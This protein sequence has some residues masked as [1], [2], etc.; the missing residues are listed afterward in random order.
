MGKHFSRRSFSSKNVNFVPKVGTF[1]PKQFQHLNFA[2]EKGRDPL[3]MPG[4]GRTKRERKRLVG[5]LFV[6]SLREILMQTKRISQREMMKRRPTN[7]FLS[8]LVRPC[9]GM[10]R[11]SRPFS[12]AKFKC[13][14]YTY[15]RYFGK[16]FTVLEQMFSLL[17]QSSH[18]WKRKN[19]W[20][21]VRPIILFSELNPA[22]GK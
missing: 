5:H 2:W 4:Q 9:P 6:G 19:V 7:P 1:V 14:N 17:E 22:F 18:F 8:L 11:G 21:N 12:R 20:K 15:I 13:W 3:D 10:S 16:I